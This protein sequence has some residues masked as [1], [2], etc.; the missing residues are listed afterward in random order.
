MQTT[1][2]ILNRYRFLFFALG[3][4]LLVV[5]GCVPR[6]QDDGYAFLARYRSDWQRPASGQVM[7]APL[8]EEASPHQTSLSAG[9]IERPEG[10]PAALPTLVFLDPG[11]GGVDTGT[12]GTT[13]DGV[14]VEEKNITLA[15]ALRTAADLRRDGIG[16]VLSRTDDSLPGSTPA[17]YSSDG[18]MLTPDGVLHDLQRRIDRANASGARV[19]LSIHLN[20]FTDPSVSGA[21]TFYDSARSFGD[22][23]KRFA[24]LVQQNVIAAFRSKGYD[25][26]D[27]GV[28]D[29]QD[30][31][32]ESLGSL[33]GSYNHL[34]LLGP[35]VP[36][37][38]RPSQMPGALS[39][40][41][42]LSNPAEATAAA[43]PAVQELIATAYTRAIEQFLRENSQ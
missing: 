32:T 39:E 35:A 9:S 41:L 27:R 42:F 12:I 14:T 28:T 37:R 25:T 13:E 24:T 19:L 31:Q 43:E 33:V 30:L 6:A 8:T 1:G 23:N 7:S 18:K 20:G 21:E 11:H 10:T 34:V 22:K 26:P 15:I 36:G 16:A 4:T 38:L 17:D 29:D 3:I 40:P 2:T 5:Q